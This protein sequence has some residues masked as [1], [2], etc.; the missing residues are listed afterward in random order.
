MNNGRLLVLATLVLVCVIGTACEGSVSTANI[1]SATLA[2]GFQDQEAVDPTTTFG[3][4]DTIHAV[5]EVANAPDD[6]KVKAVWTIVDADGGQI[7]DEKIAEKEFLTQD[8]GSVID[9]TFEPSQPLPLGKYKVDIYLNDTLNKT[10]EFQV[11]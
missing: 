5:V 8:T 6:T 11:Q 9:F 1:P 2:K 3:P 10:I 4:S 7:K